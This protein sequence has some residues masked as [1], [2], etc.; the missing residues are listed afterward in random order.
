[1]I[2]FEAVFYVLQPYRN[3]EKA[4]VMEAYMKN[5]FPY[6]GIQAPI[7]KSLTKPFLVQTKKHS[8]VDW[9]FVEQCW[10]CPYRELQYV[11]LD[12]LTL[13]KEILITTDIPKLR[14]FAEQKS[15]WDTIDVFDRLVGGIALKN[16]EVNTILLQWSIDNN[17]WIRRIAIDHQ[18]LRKEQTNKE[19]LSEIIYNNLEHTDFFIRKAIGW[20]LRDY[21]KTNPQWVCSFIEKHSNKMSKLSLREAKK[22]LKNGERN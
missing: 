3:Q 16:P 20:A 4:V 5:Q 18:L 15:W 14:S 6:L 19:L 9:E 2:S 8:V 11:A 22:Y 10:S 13:K 21:S 1:M 7:R 17:K 12:Y